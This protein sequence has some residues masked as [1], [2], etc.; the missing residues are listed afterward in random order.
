MSILIDE[1]D[2]TIV[3]GITGREGSARTKF[4]KDYGTNIIGGC[5]PG[6]GG[7]EVWNTPVYDTVKQIRDEEG[8]INVSV[9]FV[10][11]PALKNA[12]LEAIDNDVD[13][14]VSPV[15]RVPLHDIVEM[16]AYA[17]DSGTTIVGPGS[18]GVISPGKAQTGWLGGTKKLAEEVFETGKVGVISR[19]GGETTSLCWTLTQEGIGQST[20]VHVGSEPI[21]GMTPA[22]LLP[23]FE[24][25][26]QTEAVAYFGEIGTAA[27]QEM[28]EVIEERRFTKPLVTHIVGGFA[29]SGL[30]F[31][32]ASAIVEG[33]KGKYENKV[34]ALED[35]GAHVVEF[36]E[37]PKTLKE[38]I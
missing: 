36:D 30:R 4:M 34:K 17:R 32:H 23:L 37:I 35:A 2:K 22:E 6:R 25:D 7:E 26:D 33:E 3:Q 19:S 31:S 20:A 29:Q 27:E 18:L 1:G 5:T 28:A 11:G 13:V 12:V 10:P 14:V 15:E 21:L 16:V 38:V 9:T 8:E 24:E